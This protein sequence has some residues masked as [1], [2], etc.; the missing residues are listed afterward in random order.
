MVIKKARDCLFAETK[1]KKKTIELNSWNFPLV[2]REQIVTRRLRSVL[3]QALNGKWWKEEALVN[4]PEFLSLRWRQG[5]LGNPEIPVRTSKKRRISERRAGPEITQP[6][7]IPAH[8]PPC[9]LSATG[10][11]A[12][13][14]SYQEP[15]GC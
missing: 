1:H 3:I 5:I 2:V 15:R 6:L 13:L 11:Y 10:D 14:F 9:E 4:L 12:Q 8:T 7:F